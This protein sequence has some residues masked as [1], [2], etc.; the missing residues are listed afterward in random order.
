MS[1][2]G[3]VTP[4]CLLLWATSGC[5]RTPDPPAGPAALDATLVRINEQLAVMDAR[6]AEIEVRADAAATSEQALPPRDNEANLSHAIAAAVDQAKAA[7]KPSSRIEIRVTSAGLEVDGSPES[8]ATLEETLRAA[9]E[10]R[11]VT[12]EIQADDDVTHER[13]IEIMAATRAAGIERLA[14]ATIARP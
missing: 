3:L 10:T 5:G 12:V 11:D 6:L 13:I 9:I 1:P 8:L 7:P 2:K 14:I 4:L